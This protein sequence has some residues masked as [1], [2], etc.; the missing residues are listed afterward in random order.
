LSADGRVAVLAVVETIQ[1]YLGHT[2]AA[3]S[4]RDYRSLWM[5]TFAT[6]I[7]QWLQQV[8]QGWLAYTLTDSATFLGVVAFARGLP[9]LLLTL[10]GGVFADRW[11]RQ[12][13]MVTTQ[14]ITMT[15]AIILAWL[16]ATGNIQ[17]WHLVVT[18]MIAGATQSFNQPAR[19]SLAPQLAGERFMANAISLNAISFNSSRVLGPA[20]AG[21]L[22]G[23][24]SIPACYIF[25]AGLLTWAMYWTLQVRPSAHTGRQR[26]RGSVWANLVEGITYIRHSPA[27]IMLLGIAAVPVLLG[28]IYQNMMPIFARDIL[29]VGPSGMGTLMTGIG[30]G[31]VVGSFAAAALSDYPRK[32]VIMLLCGVA[33]GVGLVFFA[34]S[35]VLALSLIALALI[36]GCQALTQALNQT[37]LF[38]VT[39]NEIRGRVM[40]VF[41][42]TWGLQ[43]IVLLP[44]GWFT[45]HFGPQ[46]TVTISGILVAVTI[47]VIGGLRSELRNL[48]EEDLQEMR[49]AGRRGAPGLATK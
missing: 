39:P 23:F 18:S 45:D 3:L 27:I 36:G 37:L 8:A 2:F 17:P 41:Q 24:W 6:Q 33:F 19:Q 4:V 46:P 1:R 31:S 16:V 35:Q 10:P 9:S 11:D 29:Q 20:L 15:N 12:R 38:T 34:L 44:A 30:V 32:G 47:I 43:P 26:P 21:M 22:I 25:I 13:I 28:M 42:L 5:G 7:G 14:F 48:R 49:E 40:S